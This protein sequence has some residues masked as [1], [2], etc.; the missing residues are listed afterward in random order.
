[1]KKIIVASLFAVGAL[2][3]CPSPSDNWCLE[4]QK[5]AEKDDP[6]AECQKLKDDRDADEQKCADA[7][8]AEGDALATCI[9]A[10]GKCEEKVFGGDPEL[11]TDTCKSEA[12]DAAKCSEDNC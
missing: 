10:N 2:T 6:A 12:E 4:V 11:Y 9:L 7:C 1:M 5:C 3:A 8:K